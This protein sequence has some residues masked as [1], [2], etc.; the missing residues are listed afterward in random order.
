M[1]AVAGSVPKHCGNVVA[2]KIWVVCDDF[3]ATGLGG[4]QIKHVTH[5]NAHAANAGPTTAL[6][7]VESDAVDEGWADVL[8]S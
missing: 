2:F 5:A 8:Q 3:V 4:Q 1:I 6:L 7:R